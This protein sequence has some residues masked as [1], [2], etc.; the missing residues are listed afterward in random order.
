MRH[1]PKRPIRAGLYGRVSKDQAGGGRVGR[2]VSQQLSIGKRRCSEHEWDIAGVYSDNNVSASEW[3][4][5][6]REDWERLM[7]DIRD[8]LLDLLWVWEISRGTRERLVW[9]NLAALCQQQQ[10]LICIDSRVYDTTEPDDMRY[11]DNLIADAIHESGKTRKRI[12]RDLEASAMEGRPHGRVG[13]GFV[14]E[15][16]PETKAFRRQAPHPEQAEVVREVVRR[17]LGGETLNSLAS[18]LNQRQVPTPSGK[19]AGQPSITKNGLSGTCPGWSHKTLQDSISRVSLIGKR[20]YKGQVIAPED[21]DSWLPIISEEEYEE[22]IRK[23]RKPVNAPRRAR[24]GRARWYLSGIA[25]CDVCGGAMTS[26]GKVPSVTYECAGAYPGAPKSHVRRTVERLHAHVEAMLIRR[27][28]RPDVLE[29]FAADVVTADDVAV[30][31]REIVRLE[32]ELEQLYA[33][34]KARKVSRQ[35]AAADEEGLKAEIAK[36]EAEARP[37]ALDKFAV[38]LADPDP[39]QVKATWDEWSVDQK[40]LALLAVTERISVLRV[41]NVGSRQVSASESVRIVWKGEA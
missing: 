31:R 41:G 21:S 1:L 25:R 13:F 35:L 11:L 28:S 8:G 18:E 10:M 14:R 15:Y 16:D 38:A 32:T 5:K 23:L 36:L 22:V 9:A 39:H 12:M 34:V 40:R 2:S 4:G 29:A 24:R 20:G 19:V 7:G 27:F 3:G 30:A 33:D 26:S 6:H 17:F 37:V